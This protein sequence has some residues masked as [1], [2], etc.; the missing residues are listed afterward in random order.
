MYKDI[1]CLSYT[2]V[3]KKFPEFES[4]N[5]VRKVVT[6]KNTYELD[7]YANDSDIIAYYDVIGDSTP[8][9]LIER[10]LKSKVRISKIKL[11]IKRFNKENKE[12]IASFHISN[13][14]KYIDIT[15]VKRNIYESLMEVQA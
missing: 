14:K 2:Q 13:N 8:L 3:R 5:S 1:L 11:I 9:L 10:Q 15:I 12:Y 6:F 7:T 4:I